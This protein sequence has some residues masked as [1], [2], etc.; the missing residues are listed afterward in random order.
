MS[1]TIPGETVEAQVEKVQRGTSWARTTRV[2]VPSPDRVTPGGD[3]TCGGNV[4]A[5]IRYDRQLTI[6]R[7]I[8]RDAFTRIGRMPTPDELPVGAPRRKVT[9]CARARTYSRA[10]LGFFAKAH[11]SCAIQPTRQLLPATLSV[12]DELS[13]SLAR[14]PDAQITDVEVSENCVADQRALHLELPNGADPSSLERLPPATGVI[15][16]TCGPAESQRT[17]TLWGVAA[18]DGLSRGAIGRR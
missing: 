4:F 16:A 9:A 14:L 2:V 1:D 7:E 5:H 17:V 10:A 6:K 13:T 18:G 11:I 15:G 3:A 12:I 8:V